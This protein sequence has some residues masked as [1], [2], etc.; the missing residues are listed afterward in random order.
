MKK[1]CC[2]PDQPVSRPVPQRASHGFTLIELMV[3][4]AIVGILAAVAYPSFMSQIRKSRRSD[5]V[6]AMTQIQQV[7]ERWRANNSTYAST[8]TGLSISSTSA[9]GYYTM[10]IL[11]GA[12]APTA[13][14]Y[15]I[16]ATAV[17]GK[18]QTGDTGC[19]TLTATVENGTP[20]YTPSS[21]WSN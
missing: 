14:R 5:A 11:S 19:A 10:E 12:S 7:Q 4:V 13:T 8:L 18:T 16:T 3:A 15:Y 21:C 9:N 2:L 6:V 20:T 17:S 1:L